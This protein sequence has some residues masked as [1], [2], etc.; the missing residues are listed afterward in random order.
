MKYALKLLIWSKLECNCSFTDY[1]TF[2]LVKAVFFEAIFIIMEEAEMKFQKIYREI[3][4]TVPQSPLFTTHYFSKL[5][6]L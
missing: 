5:E 6:Y 3:N 1:K 2:M 4:K